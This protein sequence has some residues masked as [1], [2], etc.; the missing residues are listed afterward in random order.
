MTNPADEPATEEPPVRADDRRAKW[1]E[2]EDECGP[3]C[4]G[5]EWERA[6]LDAV[7]DE[8]KGAI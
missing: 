4:L 7:D 8:S 3:D 5:C 1:A 2:G 6:A